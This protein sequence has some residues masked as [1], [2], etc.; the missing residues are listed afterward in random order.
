[1]A[2][3][4]APRAQGHEFAA[5]RLRQVARSRIAIHH[6]ESHGFARKHRQGSH[7]VG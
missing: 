5:R 1:M 6:L 4:P 2:L 3:F 7:P